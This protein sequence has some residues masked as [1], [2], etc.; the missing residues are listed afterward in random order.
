MTTAARRA[1]IVLAGIIGLFVVAGTPSNALPPPVPPPNPSDEQV[2]SGREKALEAA[3][4][5]GALA[6]Q[7]ALAT[8]ELDRLQ[9]QLAETYERTTQAEANLQLAEATAAAARAAAAAAGTEAAAAKDQVVDA[10]L[11]VDHFVSASYRQGSVVGSMS[12][13]FGSSSPDDLLAR[14]AMLNAVSSFQINA[15]DLMQRSRVRMANKDSAAREAVKA[16]EVAEKAASEAKAQAHAAY[17]AAVDADATQKRRTAEL[18]ARKAELERELAAAQRAVAG[19]EG[20]QRRYQEWQAA[21]RATAQAQAAAPAAGAALAPPV[22]VGLVAGGNV[23]APT[24]G[25]ITSTY[26]P[27]WGTIH[28]G[29]DI[30]NRIG[31]PV[32][33]AMAGRVISSGPADGFGLWV[34]VRHDDGTITVY[35]H[36]HETLVSVG[37]RVG[38]GQRIAT[39]GNRGNSTGPH[40]H[41]EVHLDGSRKVDPLTWLRRNGVSTDGRTI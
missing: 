4:A 13:Y 17:Q 6:N 2:E 26:G 30:A 29:I 15:L 5:V 38:A 8:A 41:F 3:Q 22:R 23:V 11:K 25:L 18:E 21:Q 24:T 10:Q 1:G 12:A 36:I 33:S 14:A 34:R 27:R 37:D 9:I 7:I 39:V 31:T 19:L 20:Q 35:G 32:V 40:L 28:Y 16:A